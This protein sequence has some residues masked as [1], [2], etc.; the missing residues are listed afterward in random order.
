MDDETEAPP[1]PAADPMA[2]ARAVKAERAAAKAREQAEQAD[3]DAASAAKGQPVVS[4]MK[5]RAIAAY[6]GA[7]VEVRV[8][9]WGHGQLSTGG[10]HGFERYAAGAIIVIPEQRARSLFNKRWVEPTDPAFTD[11]WVAMNRQEIAAAMRAKASNDFH[12]EHGVKPGEEW[13]SSFTGGELSF[14]PRDEEFR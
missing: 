3:R 11:R 8:T 7:D 6:E 5:G 2:K 10:E 12:L 1:K 14:S 13:R 4:S 9:A